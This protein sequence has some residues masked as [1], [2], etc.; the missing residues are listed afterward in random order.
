[1]SAIE[2]EVPGLSAPPPGGGGHR[3]GIPADLTTVAVFALAAAA[4]ALYVHA[5]HVQGVPGMLRAS[6]A[7]IALFAACGDALAYV[8]IPRQ[9]LAVR[10]IFSLPL[11]AAA[12]ALVLT[13]FGIARVPLHVSLWLTLALALGA[14]VY[15]R[16]RGRGR[17]GDAVTAPGGW[18]RERFTWIGVLLIVW[19]IAL[20]PLARTGA[21]TIWGQNPDAHQVAG[22]AVLFQHVQPTGTDYALPIDTVP[23]EWRFRYPIFY[24]LAAASNLGHLD[25][26]RV[27]P[28]IVA[29]LVVIAAFGFGM[30]A[31]EYLGAPR[32]AG[33][34]VA[35]VIGFSWST[36]HLAW[37][38]YWNQLWGFA[39][40]PF[41]VLFGWRML[42]R[43][44]LRSTILFLFTLV[45]LW[46]AYP[47]AL[48]YPIVIVGAL[49]LA[50]GRR[51]WK[52]QVNA[53]KFQL[54]GAR[55]WIAVPV[56]LA[57]LAPAVVGAVLKLKE[58]V[59][60]LLTPG[61]QLWGGDIHHLLPVGPFLGVGGGILA[62]LPVL[63]LAALGV[64]SVTGGR[65]VQL[66]LG[67]VLVALCVLD[68][69]FRLVSSGAYMDYKHLTFVGVFVLVL[70]ASFVMRLLWSADRRLVAAGA[71]LLAAWAIPA[72]V[73]DRS[74][75][76]LLPQ[77]VDSQTFQIRDWIN[78]LPPGA[79]VRVDIPPGGTQLWAVYMVGSHPVSSS[80]PIRGTTYAYAHGSIRGD[81][82]LTLRYDPRY[83]Q[84]S[85]VPLAPID[86]AVNPPIDENSRF[87]LRKVIWP[88]RLDY[89]PDYSSTHLV[90]Q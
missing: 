85:K 39:M 75:A 11:G 77:Q 34:A 16:R 50:Q 3:R 57:L 41:A 19:L 78:R 49:G 70:A 72:A 28:A 48:P 68:L 58:A 38:P 9:W 1:M 51:S 25:P 83:G 90:E 18:R 86:Y 59:S 4:L 56:G 46:L 2:T 15:V 84:Q 24:P 65:R 14:S 87:V 35:A 88:K 63:V 23:Q 74:D 5:H 31:A 29:L 80:D 33:P 71:V 52:M 26:I 27:F 54:R 69:R 17:G 40:L 43:W 6:A 47:L 55:A 45:M 13:V 82:A 81:Y 8:L 10:P 61:S 42:E 89:V 30:L 36:L 67:G 73:Q 7:S 44:E 32:L 22:I 21:D 79:S 64:R 66:A 60:Q 20:I 76:F 12:G 53:R 62:A 37:H